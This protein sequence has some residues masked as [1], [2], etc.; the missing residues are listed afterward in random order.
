MEKMCVCVCLGC[1]VQVACLKLLFFSFS[2]C[3]VRFLLETLSASKIH[4]S[5]L[6][7]Q[8]RGVLY[9]VLGTLAWDKG[10]WEWLWGKQDR[11]SPLL[12]SSGDTVAVTGSSPKGYKQLDSVG[13]KDS[14]L[15]SCTGNWT[16][17]RFEELCCSLGCAEGLF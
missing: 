15:A 8:S 3:K 6:L 5:G 13:F 10:P 16:N 4:L 14:S 2:L 1:F 7:Y 17:L 11:G 12:E 9:P